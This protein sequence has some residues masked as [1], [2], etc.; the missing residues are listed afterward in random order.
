MWLIR[1]WEFDEIKQKSSST[2]KPNYYK[3]L[4]GGK[5]KKLFMIISLSL[6][7]CFMVSCQDKEAMAELEGCKAQAAV[8]EQNKEIIKRWLSEVDKENF[9]IVNE[10]ITEDCKV[11]YAGD[12]YGREWLREACEAFPQSFS[13]SVHIIDDLIAEKDKVIAQLTVKATN[14]GEFM[15]TP[16]TGKQVEYN[17]FTVYRIEAGKIRELWMDHNAFLGLMMQLGME[18]KPKEAEK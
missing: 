5:M 16:S 9:D 7:L 15:D 4:L 17:A 11:Y 18:L 2:E 8:K 1:G 13:D 12:T 14:T 10:L 6:I 3:I